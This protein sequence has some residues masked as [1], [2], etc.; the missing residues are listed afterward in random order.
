MERFTYLVKDAKG[1]S[2]KGLIEAVN[3]KQ[4]AVILHE[5]GFTII[6]IDSEAKGFT[7]PFFGKIGIGPIAQFTRQL[8]TMITSGLPLIDS[9]VVLK[10]QTE[11]AKMGEVISEITEEIQG[12]NTFASALSK[13]PAVFSVAYIN[14]IKAGEASGTLDQVLL[15]LS[16]T[17]EKEREFQGAIKGAMVYPAIII[18]GMLAVGM[19]IMIFVIPKLTQVYKD[20]DI[21]LPL[22]TLVLMAA[23]DFLVRFW[24]LVIIATVG[25]AI[26]FQ[27]YRKTPAGALAIDNLL[28]KMP[29]IGK[30]NRETSLTEFTR[31]L[32]S[33]VGAGVPIL[34]ALRI[35]G[36]AATNAAHR[37]AVG[38]VINLVE[39]GST[40][41]KALSNEATFPPIIPQM[42]SVGEETGKMADVL[43]KVSRFF[44][45]E[46]EQ[47]T[48]NLTTALEPIIMLIL[49]LMVALLMIS[50][51]LPIY[52]L[53]SAF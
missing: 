11:N 9:L 25:G 16:N 34:E 44:E 14:I 22:P 52:S 7:L 32:G 36:D 46:V 10:K 8:A 53:T 49:G 35:G 18:S 51:V 5:R 12:G 17:L 21:S 15:K 13:H 19:M 30:L 43:E 31:T 39:K 50:I 33:L 37:A 2:H 4:A 27:R 42:V 47:M 24:W 29:V 1:V 20:M 38:R 26:A 45:I 3:S 6:K 40:L 23:S 48:K 28:L 41:S